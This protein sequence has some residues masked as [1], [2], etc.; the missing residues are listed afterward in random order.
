MCIVTCCRMLSL[1]L[2]QLCPDAQLCLVS[3][4]CHN[5]GEDQTYHGVPGAGAETQRVIAH[6]ETADSVVVALQCA[7]ALAAQNVPDLDMRQHSAMASSIRSLTL[8]SKSSYPANSR[9]PDTEKATDVMPQT[10]SGICQVDVL[11]IQNANQ[12]CWR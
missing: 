11:V 2:R 10:G 9:R 1:G 8:H 5:I 6:A 7:H 4:M 3:Y 12:R